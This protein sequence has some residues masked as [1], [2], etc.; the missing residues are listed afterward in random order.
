MMPSMWSGLTA[1]PSIRTKLQRLNLPDVISHIL[2]KKFR[3][4]NFCKSSNLTGGEFLIYPEPAC[5]YSDWRPDT[6]AVYWAD[7]SE[8]IN[9][10]TRKGG[11]VVGDRDSVDSNATETLF[12]V[13]Q[14]HAL[15]NSQ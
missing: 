5:L 14:K 15:P 12:C 2:D 1:S 6:D 3:F 10:L 9:Y 8:V 7:Q 13:V 11:S 4:P